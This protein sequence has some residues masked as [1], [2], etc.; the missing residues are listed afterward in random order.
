MIVRT[1]SPILSLFLLGRSGLDANHSIGVSLSKRVKIGKT[2]QKTVL[3]RP[4]KEVKSPKS[5]TNYG[6]S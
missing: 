6:K 3:D 2:A 4:K 5:E 1:Q